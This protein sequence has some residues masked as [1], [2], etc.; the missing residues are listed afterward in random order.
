MD[1]QR[2]LSSSSTSSDGEIV[3]IEIGVKQQSHQH[4]FTQLCC[5]C[6]KRFYICPHVAAVG[7]YV[8]IL[9]KKS[10]WDQLFQS[11][12]W[13]SAPVATDVLLFE[14]VIL[15]WRWWFVHL[16]GLCYLR[17]CLWWIH[18]QQRSGSAWTVQNERSVNRW[19]Y[20]LYIYLDIVGQS[21]SER[22]IFA[23][24]LWISMVVL[25]IIACLTS[26]INSS[27]VLSLWQKHHVL[28]F[29]YIQWKMLIEWDLVMT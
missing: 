17:A 9:S 8:K 15:V 2:Y 19:K 20:V 5:N 24:S 16:W 1:Y 4:C 21:H 7:E 11:F 25:Y 28:P 23:A 12:L 29:S 18:T 10:N 27:A 14:L 26:D 13:I 6:G 3:K 22:W